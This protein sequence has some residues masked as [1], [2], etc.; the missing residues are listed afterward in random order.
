[1]LS[2]APDL[3]HRHRTELLSVAPELHGLVPDCRKTV[4]PTVVASQPGCVRAPFRTA[5]IADG[6]VDFVRDG[7][8]PGPP[9]AITFENV[10]HAEQTDLEFLSTLVRRMDPD[11]LV[12][13]ICT[14]DDGILHDELRAING[15]R[16]QLHPVQADG[17]GY[18]AMS[19]WAPP[20]SRTER[21]A[22]A[23]SY[24]RT[25]CTSDVTQL[26]RAYRELHP[27][28]MAELHERRAQQLIE[29]GQQ[30]LRLG[31]IPFH[32]ARGRDPRRAGV[33]A[34]YGAQDY[35]MSRGFYSAAIEYGYRGLELLDER[36]DEGQWWMFVTQL[37]LALSVLSRT[38]EAEALYDRARLRSTN[39]TVPMTAAHS[40]AMLSSHRFLGTVPTLARLGNGA[41]GELN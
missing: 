8:P 19:R 30:S 4:T 36:Q 3:L 7:L 38:D 23:W 2:S 41:G 15:D 24:M 11:R 25:D 1:M 29:L 22:L 18:A 10:E 16:A 35:C 32:L 27:A 28:D 9:R 6:L 13:V 40:T 17:H 34:L 26:R 20:R 21:R 5:A 31:A 12:V 14:G 37:G 33:K 39:S